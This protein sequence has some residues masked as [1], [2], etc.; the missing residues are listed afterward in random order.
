[1]A[2]ERSPERDPQPLSHARHALRRREFLRRSVAAAGIAGLGFRPVV[3]RA[4]P[5]SGLA[6]G[7]G[8]VDTTPPLGIE[9]AGFHR[10]PGKE[11]R[12]TGIR[13]PTAARALVLAHGGERAA[14]V[15]LDVCAVSRELAGRVQ[16]RVAERVGIPAAHVRL[17]ATHTH[18][19]PTFRYFR[20]WGAISPE[21]MAK[22][23]ADVVRAVELAHDDLA[24]AEM[25]MGRARVVG[26]NFNRT[27]STWKT[28]EQFGPDSTDDDRWLDTMLH[29]LLFERAGK[30]KRLWYHFSSHPVCYTDDNAG[31]DW[32]GLVAELTRSRNDLD[33]SYLQGHCGDVN[34]GDGKPWLGVPEK[35]AE[36]VHAGIDRALDRAEP[37]TIDRL[38]IRSVETP[39]PL[40]VALLQARLE[41]YR[42]DPSQCKSGTYVDERFAADWA[43]GAARWDASRTTLAVPV[44]AMQLGGVGLLF[45]PA[46]LY[47]CYGLTIR[48]DSPAEHTLVVG[49]TDDLIGY[50]PDP[51]AYKAGEYAALTVPGILDLPP[52]TP[53]AGRRFAAAASAL[54]RETIG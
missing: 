19:M 43:E 50:L 40:D 15:S 2:R 45:H 32:P 42:N 24:P 18:S 14:V 31:P 11:R 26:G 10:A 3:G 49:Y 52:Y 51:N 53:E 5:S 27:T 1:M 47:S 35:V 13:Q 23:E 33:P 9:M 17:A 7:E 12:I 48:R 37:V 4:A 46:E 41:Q 34:P 21:Y 36:A 6:V 39:I 38:R 25:L 8:R 28:D 30:P 20:Q 16:R 22:V 54:L 44:S 29:V